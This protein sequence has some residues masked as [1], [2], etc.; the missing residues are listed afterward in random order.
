[1]TIKTIAG[2]FKTKQEANETSQCIGNNCSVYGMAIKDAEGYD[3]DDCLYYVEQDD[4][5]LSGKIFGYD[6]AEF[7]RKQYK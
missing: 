3:I 2:P 5:I 7:L 1:M 4:S 6:A